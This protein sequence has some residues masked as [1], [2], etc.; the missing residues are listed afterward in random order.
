MHDLGT[1]EF[2]PNDVI[3][4]DLVKKRIYCILDYW[5]GFEDNPGLLQNYDRDNS[6]PKEWL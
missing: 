4:T 3:K 6:L 2:A 5:F 1:V